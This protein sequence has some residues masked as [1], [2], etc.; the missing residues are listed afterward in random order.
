LIIE[1][2][3]PARTTVRSVGELEYWSLV[4]PRCARDLAKRASKKIP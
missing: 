4:L 3:L 1:V 2:C